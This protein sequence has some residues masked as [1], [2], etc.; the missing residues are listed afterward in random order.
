MG[1]TGGFLMGYLASAFV[2]GHLADQGYNKTFLQGLTLM[3]LGN[4]VLYFFGATYLS[5]LLGFEKMAA[6]CANFIPAV[7]VKIGFG[8]AV[9]ALSQNKIREFFK[10]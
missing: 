10:V 3:V 7:F 2:V 5:Y 1:P 6:I 8:A 4:V 9:I